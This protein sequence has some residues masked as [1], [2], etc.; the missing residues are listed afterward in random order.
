MPYDYIDC[1]VHHDCLECPLSIC[2]FDDLLWFHR[3]LRLGRWCAMAEMHLGGACRGH[4]G[5]FRC[6]RAH[7]VPEHRQG[8]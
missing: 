6:N 4:C 1:E 7:G 3:S 8:Q 5:G 2:K